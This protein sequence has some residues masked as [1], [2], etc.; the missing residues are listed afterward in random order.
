MLCRRVVS[1]KGVN[2]V[3]V[4]EEEVLDSVT[5][6]ESEYCEGYIWLILK[7]GSSGDGNMNGGRNNY[8][9]ISGGVLKNCEFY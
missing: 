8:C 4:K 2:M 9:E 6:G 1:D 7:Q 3:M 5:G